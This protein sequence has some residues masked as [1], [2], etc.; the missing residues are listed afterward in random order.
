MAATSSR[1]VWIT[2]RKDVSILKEYA[3]TLKLPFN[4]GNRLSGTWIGMLY[5]YFQVLKQSRE[6]VRDGRKGSPPHMIKQK[7]VRKYRRKFHCAVLIETG[8]YLGDMVYAMRKDFKVIHS[9][10]LDGELYKRAK[11]RFYNY[12]HIHLYNGNSGE[13][14]QTILR[15]LHQPCIFWLDAHYSAGI[16]ARGESDTPIEEELQYIFGHECA[17][18]SVILIDDARSFNGRNDYPLITAIETKVKQAGYCSFQVDDDIIRISGKV[19]SFV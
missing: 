3:I 4:I 10:E 16:T 9:I 1:S 18:A 12:S 17:K 7:I 19:E 6:W 2:R 14:L 13:V 15:G 5:E 8:T 11:A